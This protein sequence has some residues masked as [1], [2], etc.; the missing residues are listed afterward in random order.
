MKR[1]GVGS[2]PL[3]VNLKTERPSKSD[4]I[5]LSNQSND[6][7]SSIG[8]GNA[9]PPF[10]KELMG[11]IR[12]EESKDFRI[13][14]HRSH[15]FSEASQRPEPAHKTDELFSNVK[16]NPAARIDSIIEAESEAYYQEHSSENSA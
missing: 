11:E 3:K 7:S 13:E 6:D 8:K 15:S 16:A 9:S 12:T 5:S 4:E 14:V 10:A 2:N 1:P